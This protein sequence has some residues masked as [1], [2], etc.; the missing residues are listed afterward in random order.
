MKPLLY[1]LLL[2]LIVLIYLG[3]HSF[4]GVALYLK[5]LYLIGIF[6]AWAVS[7]LCLIILVALIKSLYET[8]IRKSTRSN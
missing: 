5:L 2:G 8:R 3:T 4:P 7:G 6:I 1:W